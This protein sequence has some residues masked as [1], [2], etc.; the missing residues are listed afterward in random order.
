MANI[1]HPGFYP[2]RVYGG[3]GTI[4]YARRRTL[5]N[6]TNAI[7]L[8]DAV[9]RDSS[10]DTIRAATANVAVDSVAMG[11]SYVTSANG[12]QGAKALPA[13]TTYSGSIVDP[14]DAS[15]VFVVENPVN[16]LFRCSV[17]EAIAMTDLGINYAMV[18]GSAVNGISGHELDATGRDTTNTLPWRVT[19]FVFTPDND[20]DSADAHVLALVNAGMTEP[21]LSASTGT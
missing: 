4:T 11:V 2:A 21:A 8:Q 5:S 7:S 1:Q 3:N 14:V 17:D 12:R 13:A 10:G 9:I 16:V 6:N 20:V 15:Y 18:L 19:G